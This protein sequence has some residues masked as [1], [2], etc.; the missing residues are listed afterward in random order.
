MIDLDRLG[1]PMTG[2]GCRAEPFGEQHREALKAACAEDR[3]I[4]AIYSTSFGPEHFDASIDA[5]RAKPTNRTFV[6][7]GRATSWSG[8]SSCLGDVD[9]GPPAR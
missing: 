8:M 9:R 1:Q 5:L 6:L 7:F 3:E 4:W 2:D